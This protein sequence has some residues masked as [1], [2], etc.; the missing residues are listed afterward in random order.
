MERISDDQ[1]L[2]EQLGIH[3]TKE[4]ILKDD[5]D[6][7]IKPAIPLNAALSD[8]ITACRGTEVGILAL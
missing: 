7:V 2:F 1:K 4:C 6:L 5:I 3:D 8:L